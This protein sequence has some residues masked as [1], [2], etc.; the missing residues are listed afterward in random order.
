MECPYCIKQ[1]KKQIPSILLENYSDKINYSYKNF[2]IPAHKNAS[3]E[4]QAAKC[5]EE[6]S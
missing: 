6:I 5:I 1:H 4:A 2:P 3:I